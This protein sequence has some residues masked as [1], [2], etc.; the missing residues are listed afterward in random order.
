MKQVKVE[1]REIPY[2]ASYEISRTGMIRNT[3]THAIRKS[4]GPLRYIK[5]DGTRQSIPIWKVMN[6]IWPE[7][8]P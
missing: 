1:W 3:K 6:E 5:G 4:K 2:S 8:H 7:V